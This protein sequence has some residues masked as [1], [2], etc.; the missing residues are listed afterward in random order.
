MQ[1]AV[2]EAVSTM[3][4]IVIQSTCEAEYCMASLCAMAGSYIKK[5]FN[6]MLVHYSDRPLTI[7]G[8]NDSQSAMD[9]AT[10]PKETSRIRHIARRFHFVRHCIAN[11]MVKLFKVQGTMN[12]ANCLTTPLLAKELQL[13]AN[14][15]Q[16]E[17]DHRIHCFFS[18]IVA[19]RSYRFQT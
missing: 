2:V 16:T 14:V 12:P 10:S 7:P 19:R 5:V 11:G 18:T 17:V 3:P 6:E 9:T 8:G 15:L 4:A 1:G 13:E